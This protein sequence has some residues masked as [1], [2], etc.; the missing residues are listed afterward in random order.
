MRRFV[1]I[2]FAVAVL[3]FAGCGGDDKGTTADIPAGPAPSAPPPPKASSNLKDTKSKPTIA[4]PKG[5]PPKKLVVRDIVKGKG[6]AAKKGDQLSMQYVGVTFDDGQ[7]F[8]SSWDSGSPIDFKLGTGGVIEGW[9]RGVVGIKPGGRREL[10][11]PSKLAYGAQGRP[12]SIP[13]NAALV[14][15]VDAL[16]VGK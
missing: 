4:K 8:D 11:I 7:E 1:P 15:I 16:S 13:P 9:D 2:L 10:I 6:R 3:A 14:F 5:S 12:P